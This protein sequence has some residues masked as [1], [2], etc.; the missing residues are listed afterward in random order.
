MPGLPVPIDG[1]S[2]I[3]GATAVETVQA[4][5]DRLV[6]R[7][8]FPTAQIVGW[9]DQALLYMH[10]GSSGELMNAFRSASIHKASD[11]I[12]A[13][14]YRYDLTA[15]A[16]VPD[17]LP[18]QL[19]AA[20]VFDISQASEPPLKEAT[21]YEVCNTLWCEPNLRYVLNFHYANR[22]VFHRPAFLPPRS[23]TRSSPPPAEER[24][25]TTAA[26]PVS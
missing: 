9:V 7:T 24:N 10:A 12:D 1:G 18:D 26:T 5:I 11:L 3:S 25:G 14:G 16:R 17:P 8:Y 22:V 21:I 13:V 23:D 4:M 2:S 6:R 20:A 15:N 19:I